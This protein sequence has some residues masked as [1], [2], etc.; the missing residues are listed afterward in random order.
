ML[1]DDFLV[2]KFRRDKRFCIHQNVYSASGTHTAPC[3]VGIDVSPAAKAVRDV[4]STI[5]LNPL[6]R[7]RMS[8]AIIL[9]SYIPSWSGQG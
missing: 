1:Q 9:N 2:F 8:G 5:Y 7:L 6:S 3:S 4:I